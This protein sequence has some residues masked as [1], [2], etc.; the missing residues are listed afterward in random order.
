[1]DSSFLGPTFFALSPSPVFES[2]LFLVDYFYMLVY[3]VGHPLEQGLYGAQFPLKLVD[4]EEFLLG[5]HLQIP[6]KQIEHH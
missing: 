4:H 1:M 6:T 2:L 3:W 5:K